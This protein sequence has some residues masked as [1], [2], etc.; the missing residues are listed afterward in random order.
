MIRLLLDTH[1]W[2]WMVTAPDRLSAAARRLVVPM[3]NE[4][5]L[6]AVSPWEVAIKYA[7]GKLRFSAPIQ[8]LIPEWMAQ[9]GVIPLP[10]NHR[11]ATQVASLPLHHADPFD[12]LLIAQ[13]QVEQLTVL[14]TDPDF[15]RY[16]VKVSRA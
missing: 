16:D 10:I 9:A 15:D 14:T 5:I 4:L 11:H 3:D 6:S 1:I 12:R 7:T 2:L 13:A 8:T